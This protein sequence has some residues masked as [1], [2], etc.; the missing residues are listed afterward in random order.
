MPT[1]TQAAILRSLAICDPGKGPLVS[2]PSHH[3]TSAFAS[4]LAPGWVEEITSGPLRVW[5]ITPTGR[6]A[7]Y[8]LSLR[9]LTSE[10]AAEC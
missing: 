5:K 2:H 3:T 1:P 8:D 6:S 7:L 9:A 4:C 10:V